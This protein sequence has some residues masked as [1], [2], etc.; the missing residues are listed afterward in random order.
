[1]K[2]YIAGKISDLDWSEVEKKFKEAADA[3]RSA[4]HVALCPVEMFP[5]NAVWDWAEYMLND[6]RLIWNHADAVLML[7]D[8]EDSKGARLERHAA[9]AGGKPVY[10]ALEDV[11][12]VQR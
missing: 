10:Y 1:M 12:E 4:G 8:W 11:P 6:L 2:I 9:Q 5:E 7:S 3:L